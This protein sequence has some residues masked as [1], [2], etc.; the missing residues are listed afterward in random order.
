ML[1]QAFSQQ[2]NEAEELKSRDQIEA[3]R[4]FADNNS[5]VAE[6]F[7]SCLCL[8]KWELDKLYFT[9]AS[10]R[11]SCRASESLEWKICPLW[12]NY[13]NWSFSYSYNERQRS[14]SRGKGIK[15]IAL[16]EYGSFKPPA[17]HIA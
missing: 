12:S 14:A 7:K 9:S 8:M 15:L 17:F 10:M 4:F 13:N 2:S 16:N 6:F 11:S 1:T 3:W 5:R